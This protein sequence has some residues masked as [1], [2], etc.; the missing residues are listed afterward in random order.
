MNE[1][2]SKS[3]KDEIT[4]EAIAAFAM[5]IAKAIKEEGSVTVGRNDGYVAEVNTIVFYEGEWYV[6]NGEGF[7]DRNGGLRDYTM[8]EAIAIRDIM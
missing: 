6:S 5:K 1:N 4:D 7:Y 3:E 2:I 8:D